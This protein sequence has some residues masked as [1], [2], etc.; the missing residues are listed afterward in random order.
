SLTATVTSSATVS[1]SVTFSEGDTVLGTAD[2][3]S[4]GTATLNLS[5]VTLSA[6]AHTIT[7]AYG[8]SATL[9]TSTTTFTLTV[10]EAT[11]S[12]VASDV[13][14]PEGSTSSVAVTVTS[15]A[16]AKPGGTVQVLDA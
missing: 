5:E 2:I 3:G 9:L 1:G 16:T 15:S 7:A 11:T 6:G 13:P 14:A 10:A 12:V 8:G 4:D